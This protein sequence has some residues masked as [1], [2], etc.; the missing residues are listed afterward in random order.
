MSRE[1]KRPRP[2]TYLRTGPLRDVA[3]RLDRAN[4]VFILRDSVTSNLARHGNYGRTEIGRRKPVDQDWGWQQPPDLA[5]LRPRHLSALGS[6]A[7]TACSKKNRP[8]AAK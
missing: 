5:V 4:S 6:D 8:A 3:W 1:M 7:V 2:I